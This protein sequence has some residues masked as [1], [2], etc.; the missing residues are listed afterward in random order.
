M[1]L[2]HAVSAQPY[3]VGRRIRDSNPCY[4]RERLVKLAAKHLNRAEEGHAEVLA[5]VEALR[6]EF[7]DF[8]TAIGSKLGV[9]R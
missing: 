5:D 7:R 4:R 1:C 3:D 9:T 8:R 2:Y 6:A